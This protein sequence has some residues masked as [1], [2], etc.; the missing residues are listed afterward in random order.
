MNLQKGKKE[1]II[2]QGDKKVD[3]Y[4]K[5]K[6]IEDEK[7]FKLITGVTREV[8]EKMLEV[9][10][11]EYI[12]DHAGGGQ[13][14]MPVELRLTLALE[15][16]REYRSQRHMSHAHGICKRSINNSIL[17]V[18]YRLSGR[19]DF[20]LADIKERFKPK[21]DESLIGIVLVDVE[22]QPIERPVENQKDSYCLVKSK[23]GTK[24]KKD[25]VYF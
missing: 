6:K 15:Y 1:C 7:E 5:I 22:E 19:E 9:L 17:W 2:M 4:E 3:A 12:K 11:E 18:E 8:F 24:V 10:R 20:Q 23:T 14:G 21:E 13:P 16:W 25:M